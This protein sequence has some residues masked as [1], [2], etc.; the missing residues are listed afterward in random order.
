MSV[1]H[2]GTAHVARI[3]EYNSAQFC[4]SR[5]S[6]MKRVLA[7]TPYAAWKVHTI[8]ETTITRACQL[9]GAEVKH[10]LCDRLLSECDMYSVAEATGGRPFN[11]CERCQES[12]TRILQEAG[13][14]YE[15]LSRYIDA[16]EQREAFAWAQSLS[17]AE[18]P[19]A[20]FQDQPLGEWVTT[21]VA[22]CFRTFPIRFDDWQTVNI[23]RGYLF[24]AALAVL[25]L[26][27]V[28]DQWRP[29]ALV[30]FNGHRS[31]LRVALNLARQRGIRVL[32]HERPLSPGS[33]FFAENANCLS[34]APW[35]AFWRE[36]SA[37]PLR[38]SELQQTA[39]FIRGRRFGRSVNLTFAS[40]PGGKE[41]VK[42]IVEACG[43][44][45]LAV[46]FTSSNDESAAEV[47][48][49]G[50]FR[51]QNE[52][53]ETVL[54]AVSRRPDCYL[55]IR[56]HPCIAGKGGQYVSSSEVEWFKALV[57]K[58]PQ[59]ATV[60]QP[61]DPVSSYDLMDLADVGLAYGSTAG[62]EMLSLGK[63]VGLV[64]GFAIYEDLAGV[65]LMKNPEQVDE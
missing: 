48:L 17:L 28:L 16:D 47:E 2:G 65:V 52:W 25:G 35:R 54:A 8:T 44:R 1:C 5:I 31:V 20:R 4:E 27:R 23:Y 39:R 60:I 34:L 40:P 50:P 24:S 62:L 56:A 21:S 36:W 22:S 41:G 63:P 15:W 19:L 11:L 7:F 14:P 30:L 26:G 55:V 33:S 6:T 38:L 53:I 64:P 45:K 37:I 49:Q 57:S 10:I 43:H 9:R 61:D 13:L 42:H 58:L 46:L 32:V 12:A 59:N 29:D 51:S 18:L 3:L